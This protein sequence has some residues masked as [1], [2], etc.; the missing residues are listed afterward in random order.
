[1]LPKGTI[2]SYTALQ[3]EGSFHCQSLIFRISFGFGTGCGIDFFQ[4]G[5]GKRC[6]FGIFSLI[7]FIK[8]NQI[9]LAFLQS[10]DNKAHLKPPVAQMYIADHIMSGITADTLDTFT[11]NC[12]TDMSHMKRLGHIGS[13]VVDNDLLRLFWHLKTVFGICCHFL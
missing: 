13:A 10:H 9:R 8:I 12:G 5:D 11:D 2:S 6:F 4:L 1:M 7:A 3:L